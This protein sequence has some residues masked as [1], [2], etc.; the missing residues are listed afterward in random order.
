MSLTVPC[1][2]DGLGYLKVLAPPEK[3]LRWIESKLNLLGRVPHYVSMDQKIYG[4]YGVLPTANTPNVDGIG[5]G[6]YIGSTERLGS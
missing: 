4:R 3:V 2:L 5:E 1:A 6:S